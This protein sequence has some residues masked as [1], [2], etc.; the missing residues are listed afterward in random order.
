MIKT[1]CVRY[2]ICPLDVDGN[3]WQSFYVSALDTDDAIDQ[4]ANHVWPNEIYYAQAD[5]DTE[6]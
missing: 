2:K 4:C 1:Y 6:A 5:E 3:P